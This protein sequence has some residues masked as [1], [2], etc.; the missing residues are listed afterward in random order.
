MKRLLLLPVLL[1]LAGCPSMRVQGFIT[2]AETREPVGTCQV[3]V[4]RAYAHSDP[5]G[6]YMI[7]ARRKEFRTKPMNLVCK[8]YE[9]R[10]LDA[11]QFRTKNRYIDLQVT[12]AVSSK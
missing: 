12:P 7:V 11:Y 5:A 1:T 8:G 4:G 3:T 2:D 6:H 10:S 9:P